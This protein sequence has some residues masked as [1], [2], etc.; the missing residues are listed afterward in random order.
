MIEIW[1]F[2]NLKSEMNWK[3][4]KEKQI[5]ILQIVVLI[6]TLRSCWLEIWNS[7]EKIWIWLE[8]LNLEKKE[9]Q[10]IKEKK[11]KEKNNVRDS[12]IRM[13]RIPLFQP[14]SRLGDPS[15]VAQFSHRLLSPPDGAHLSD[16]PLPPHWVTCVWDPAVS[17][18]STG[19]E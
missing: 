3:F 18:I 14:N 10:N 7:K 1:E 9:M 2:G 8:H 13:G 11:R 17:F 6:F 19:S 16:L 4:G 15:H 5:K 12:L